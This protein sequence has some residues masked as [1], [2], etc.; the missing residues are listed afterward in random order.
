MPP[1]LLRIGTRGSALALLQAAELCRRLAGAHA[2]LAAPQAIE[3]VIIKTSGDKAGDR[4]LAEIGGKGLFTKEIEE[5]L[6]A[7]RI[8]IAV[9]SLKDLPSF[10]P[11]GLVL[12]AHLPREDPRD[13][14]VSPRAA[15]LGE[16][17]AG[18]SVGTSSPRRRAQLLHRRPDLRILPL[19]GNVETRLKKLE[20][21]AVEATVLALAGVKRLG[22]ADRITAVLEPEEML[23]AAAQGAIGA[24]SRADDA[25]TRDFLAAIDDAPTAARVTA[26]R[27]VLAALG[28]SCRTPIAALAE[29]G[30]GGA[31]H[32]RAMII[33]PDGSER[34]LTE[35][36]GD[37]A[38]GASL[39][40]DAGAELKR[41]AGPGYFDET[42]L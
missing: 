19:R 32:L 20:A 26:E 3:T 1:P 27:A 38:A 30:A 11:D 21:G 16:L 23:P 13:A 34:L 37:V 40:A 7:R 41:R 31:L 22:L 4:R 17:P 42:Q 12:A 39:G 9:H 36:R 14:W 6:L 24:E 35:R 2:A 25:K 29:L 8:D 28:G 15:Q 33:R 5:A 18:A 10:L